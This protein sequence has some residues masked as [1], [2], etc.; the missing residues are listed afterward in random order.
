MALYE[1]LKRTDYL[2]PLIP[3]LRSGQ[4]KLDL[5]RNKIILGPNAF[6]TEPDLPWIFS[7]I[8]QDR[9]CYKWS[10]IYR[11]LYGMIP[12]GCFKCWKVVT[13]PRTLGQVFKLE[14]LQGKLGYPG[15]CGIE[16][17]LYATFKGI[18][19]GFWYVPMGFSVEE[20]REF[21]K[22]LE[23]EVVRNVGLGI[24]VFLKRACTEIENLVGPSNEWKRS[25]AME[26]MED[27]LDELLDV[28]T[29]GFSQPELYKRHVRASWIEYAFERG[30]ETVKDFV[31]NFP[32]SFGV[33]PTVTYD[34][35]IP[36]ITYTPEEAENGDYP[37]TQRL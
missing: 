13:R 11:K 7:S 3:L 20:A 16:K 36:K 14:K 21:C 8:P 28:P 35:E 24:P 27:E 9:Y 25:I 32:G 29:P 18:Y 15:K 1:D 10:N 12:R 19:A 2:E 31:D 34:K 33:T 6:E 23:G 37:K 4:L 17:R 30:D 5:S 26:A 22:M